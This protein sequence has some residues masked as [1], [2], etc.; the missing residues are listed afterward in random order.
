M[1]RRGCE[2]VFSWIEGRGS[3]VD[4]CE[5]E[6]CAFRVSTGYFIV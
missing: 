5:E 1:K 2:A 4:F 6:V 3:R